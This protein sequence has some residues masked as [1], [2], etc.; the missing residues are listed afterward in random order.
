MAGA[1]VDIFWDDESD[2]V[3]VAKLEWLSDD[4]TGAVTYA[5]EEKEK[6]MVKGMYLFLM[7]TKP[8]TATPSNEYKIVLEDD[9]GVDLAGGELDK[10]SNSAAEQAVPK[11]N[12]KVFGDRVV[13]GGLT[14]KVSNAGNAKEGTLMLFFRR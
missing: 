6:A 10:R 5:F 2:L 3:T 12:S 13:A 9:L 7:E 1:K 14:V 11:L 8:G 4:A